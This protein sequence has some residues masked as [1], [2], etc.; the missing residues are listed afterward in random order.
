M[1]AK[2]AC[3]IVNCTM[4]DKEA[5]GLPALSLS[6]VIVTRETICIGVQKH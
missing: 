6:T 2:H 1:R 3:R 5:G 4:R